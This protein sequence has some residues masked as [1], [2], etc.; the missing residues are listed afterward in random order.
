VLRAVVHVQQSGQRQYV[1]TGDPDRRQF[2]Q[3]LISRVRRYGGSERVER[4]A[5]GVHPR[6]LSGVGLDPPGPGHVFAVP[7]RG[8]GGRCAGGRG[9][10]RDRTARERRRRRRCRVSAG[11]IIGVYG[12]R[13]HGRVGG[14]HWSR[15]CA[16]A[17]FGQIQGLRFRRGRQRGL[18]AAA[19]LRQR[20]Y[21]VHVAYVVEQ[22]EAHFRRRL[23]VAAPRPERGTG[24]YVDRPQ[25]AGRGG[26]GRPAELGCGWTPISVIG[27]V[28]PFS[29]ERRVTVV[30]ISRR[31]HVHAGIFALVGGRCM[32]FPFDC[33][34]G[35]RL[36]AAR[37]RRRVV[38]VMFSRVCKTLKI[39][40]MK[41]I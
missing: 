32:R 38:C 21:P 36:C 10:L 37:R 20:Q 25:H 6:P 19:L 13:V 39:Y 11:G 35:H 2:G 29:F 12:G 7:G 4:R 17:R 5:D 28:Q 31:R 33:H 41:M 30:A 15:P 14:V 18:F 9:G 23:L 22:P 40:I 27:I 34:G 8:R 16:M 3:L 24:V 1:S 26:V